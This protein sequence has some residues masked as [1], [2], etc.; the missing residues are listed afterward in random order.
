MAA[1]ALLE[2]RGI[3][4]RFSGVTVLEDVSVSLMEGE[5]LSLVG[6]NG[7]GKS[8]LMRIL[9]GSHP[10]G[11]FDGEI[12]V[13]NAPRSFHTPKDAHEVGIRMIYQEL[14]L[15]QDLSIAENIFLGRLQQKKKWLANWS[16]MHGSTAGL[17][18]RVGLKQSPQTVLRTLNAGQ[19]QLVA[20]AKALAHDPRILVLDEPSAALT[21]EETNRL[22][23]LLKSL[24]AHGISCIYISHKLK[25]VYSVSDRITVLRDG[26]VVAQREA[27]SYPS[28]QLVEDMIG[29]KIENMYPKLSV[30]IGAEVLRA[31]HFTVQHPQAHA[32]N[33]V[34]DAGFTVRRGEILGIAGLVGSGRSEFVNAVFGAQ[35][36][37]GR[38]KVFV[39]G[40][41]VDIRGPR[42]AI[43]AGIG[44]VTED[45]KANGFIRTLDVAQNV[46]LAS[47]RAV[48]SHAVIVRSKEEALAQR[49]MSSLKIKAPGLRAEILALSG[50]N[51]Q[52]VVLS[53]W[54]A[55]QLKVLILDEPTRGVDVGAK[56]DIYGLMA[57]LA[58][59]GVGI[60]M[61]SSELP[62]LLAM[63]D[64]FITLAE[65]RIVDEFAKSDA[66]A[67]R[68]MSAA[69]GVHKERKTA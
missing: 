6:E 62:E 47:L 11:S 39:E 69:T 35:E 7:A 28:Q 56:V 27:S 49:F 26:R 57:E 10:Y 13:R 19:Q 50:G 3:T 43:R 45:R 8:T 52:K 21:E 54:L 18:E 4:K 29:R 65:G 34:T 44:L 32:K 14:S 41:P 63:C 36:H 38:G 33:V 40:R 60:V 51:Q 53:K 67:G 9:S 24:K 66:S 15:H 42:D 20:I 55:T 23:E 12:R 58:R 31:E 16:G 46:S 61:I 5:I 2:M 25:E 22:L 64:R 17:L 30:P 59:Q 37:D 68:I 1:A 48:S